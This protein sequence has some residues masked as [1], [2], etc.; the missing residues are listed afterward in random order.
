MKKL[1]LF[2]FLPIISFAQLTSTQSSIN[3]T[4][5]VQPD[6][7]YYYF[8]I[9]NNGSNTINLNV[10]GTIVSQENIDENISFQMCL[11]D[12]NGGGFGI[13]IPG[14]NIT[15]PATFPVG[16]N[17]S[18]PVGLNFINVSV[19]NNFVIDVE[20]FDSA[21]PSNSVTVTLNVNATSEPL[22]VLENSNS[23]IGSIYPNPV[24]DF[25]N[26]PVEVMSDQT[27]IF[28]YDVTG[29]KVKSEKMSKG[30]YTYTL[31]L[32]QLNNG[33]YIV[34]IVN[35]NGLVVNKKFFKN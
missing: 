19:E 27:E 21:N 20:I 15:L 2:L 8:D 31:N 25:L 16:P 1:L 13:C 7:Q 34:S 30:K 18:L 4:I 5:Q 14:L 32:N 3:A 22:N 24:K 33:L 11:G 6:L 29:K 28:I 17:N 35:E 12:F 23:S 9:Q 10:A 26:I